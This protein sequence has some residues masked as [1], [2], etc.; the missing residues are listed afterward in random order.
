MTGPPATVLLTLKESEALLWGFAMMGDYAHE[1][2]DDETDPVYLLLKAGY[3]PEQFEAACKRLRPMA[4]DDYL[5]EPFSDLE[6]MILR[7]AVENTS[8]I[9]TYR[10]HAPTRDSPMLIREALTALRTLAAKLEDFG[11]EVNYIPND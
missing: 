4:L 2:P 5:R 10:T 3:R 1:P 6:K 8:W 7:L 11:I 9:T